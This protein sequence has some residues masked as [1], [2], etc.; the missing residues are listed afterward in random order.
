MIFRSGG[1][2]ADDVEVEVMVMT[3]RIALGL[4]FLVGIFWSLGELLLALWGGGWSFTSLRVAALVV[5]GL[6]FMFAAPF[7]L[8]VGSL[9]GLYR[10]APLFSF[11]CCA[12]GSLWFS[13]GFGQSIYDNLHR[14]SAEAPMGIGFLTLYVATTLLCVFS[15]LWTGIVWKRNRRNLGA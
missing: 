8:I 2:C 13:E 11:I 4:T 1:V 15:A 10:K 12:V 5:S 7:C 14:N 6:A 3:G 9:L